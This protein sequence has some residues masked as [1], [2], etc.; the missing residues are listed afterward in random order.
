M[1]KS[2]GGNVYRPA[3]Y[4]FFRQIWADFVEYRPRIVFGDEV[5]WLDVDLWQWVIYAG[6]TEVEKLATFCYYTC[7][8]ESF[9]LFFS[10][11]WLPRRRISADFCSRIWGESS[12]ISDVA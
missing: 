6:R 12:G 2:S 11:R 5:S 9:G 8:A 1:P 4:H 3:T 7:S 10:D